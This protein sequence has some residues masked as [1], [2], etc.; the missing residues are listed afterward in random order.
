MSTPKPFISFSVERFGD[1]A[2]VTV[3]RI[4]FTETGHQR[5]VLAH[6]ETLSRG[7]T[8][9]AKREVH[10]FERAQVSA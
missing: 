6:Y 1:T 8:A 3:A 4:T 10:K 9:S 2:M 5:E 7:A